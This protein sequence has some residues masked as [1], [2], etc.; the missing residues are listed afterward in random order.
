MLPKKGKKWPD[1]QENEPQA[2][3][4]CCL[5]THMCTYSLIKGH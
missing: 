2:H 5:Q 3:L 1:F 4:T